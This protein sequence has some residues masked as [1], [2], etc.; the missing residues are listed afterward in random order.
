MDELSEILGSATAGVESPYFQLNIDGGDPVFRER[1]YCY[2][3]YHQLRMKWPAQ[4]PYVLNGEIDKSAHPILS[5]LG[6][7]HAKPDFLIHTPGDMKGNH[8]IIEVKHDLSTAGVQKDLEILNLF[9][10]RARYTRA[11][12]LVYG[13]KANKSGIASVKAIAEKF[14]NLAPIE[15]WIHDEVGRPATHVDTLRRPNKTN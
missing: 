8:A 15:L 7:G 6:I 1:V 9:V 13:P 5:T 3:L 10:E 14:D 11:I 12:Y 2:E 4:C